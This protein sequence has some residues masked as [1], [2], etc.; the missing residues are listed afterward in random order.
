MCYC[1]V[2]K[3]ELSSEYLGRYGKQLLNQFFYNFQAKCK[4]QFFHGMIEELHSII[5]VI[6]DFTMHFQM[7]KWRFSVWVNMTFLTY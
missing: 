7:G 4:L 5:V 2:K 6:I 3:L 1:V